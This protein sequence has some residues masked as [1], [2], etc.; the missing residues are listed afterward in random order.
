MS[1]ITP[2]QPPPT[3]LASR[4]RRLL[5]G[6]PPDTRIIVPD[7]TWDD[8][9]RFVDSIGEG[10]NCRVAFDGKDIEI[11]TL[12]PRHDTLR[13]RLSAFVNLVADG[14][15]IDLEA[16]GSTTWMRPEVN[17]GLESDLCYYFDPEKLA[18]H[19]AAM[20]R[21]SN[22]VADYP[23][24][25][26][27]IEVDLSPSKIDRPGIYAALRVPEIWRFRDDAVSI[28]QLT[29]GEYLAAAASRFLHV[30][31]EDVT[32]WLLVEKSRPRVDWTRRLRE[33]VRGEL[34]ARAP[35][36]K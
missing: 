2:T 20:E 14:L 32:R 15:A 25:D 36:G 6:F 9:E 12:G 31:A 21:K 5:D 30:R 1:T 28:E 26:L 18:V 35:V 3:P 10:E 16:L 7:V 4:P 17:R 11:M 19:A 34:A 22:D 33:W 29:S 23:N 27:A 24:P 13:E 8:Y